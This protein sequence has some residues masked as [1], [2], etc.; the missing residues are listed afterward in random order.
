[1][2]P[3][4]ELVSKHKKANM[5]KSEFLMLE[6]LKS[7]PHLNDRRLKDT[8]EAARAGFPPRRTPGDPPNHS[9][10]KLR[11]NFWFFKHVVDLVN[12]HPRGLFFLIVDENLEMDDSHKT[13]SG[14]KC[15][16]QIRSALDPK[17]EMPRKR[18][19]TLMMCMIIWYQSN[20]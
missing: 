19:H 16:K 3:T 20:L 12:S 6:A 8:T 11:E 15:I 17:Q 5:R 1:M 9:G 7:A 14:S 18:V 10:P 4:V 2:N 13:I